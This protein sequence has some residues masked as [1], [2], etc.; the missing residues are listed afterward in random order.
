MEPYI[1]TIPRLC[2]I[3]CEIACLMQAKPLDHQPSVSRQ[4]V[5]LWARRLNLVEQVCFEGG[6][7]MVRKPVLS[8]QALQ[9][10]RLHTRV[11]EEADADPLPL[12]H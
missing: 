5:F 11:G 8:K 1:S 9:L 6:F 3:G 12:F 10:S 4:G 7:G 2:R